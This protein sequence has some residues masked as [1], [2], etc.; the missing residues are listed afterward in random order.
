[1][2]ICA[3]IDLTANT[4][5][6]TIVPL[7]KLREFTEQLINIYYLERAYRLSHTLSLPGED[8]PKFEGWLD[9]GVLGTINNKLRLP[10]IHA[11][12]V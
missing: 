9:T 8:E 5:S 10:Y 4:L 6:C 2:T 11:K 1:M 12:R 7:L 3:K